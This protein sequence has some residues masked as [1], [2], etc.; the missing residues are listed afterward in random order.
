[1]VALKIQ[2]GSVSIEG[3]AKM[4]RAGATSRISDS[5]GVRR[6]LRICVFNKDPGNNDDSGLGTTF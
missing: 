2:C 4:Q 1:M 6:G 3:L 5:A